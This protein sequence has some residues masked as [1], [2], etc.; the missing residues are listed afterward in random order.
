MVG[1][2][3]K[4]YICESFSAP[5]CPLYIGSDSG[6][7]SLFGAHDMIKTGYDKELDNDRIR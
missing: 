4:P 5:D 7:K 3:P 1:P 6:D 2:L